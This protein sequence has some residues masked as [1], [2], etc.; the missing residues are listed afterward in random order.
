MPS[1]QNHSLRHNKVAPYRSQGYRPATRYPSAQNHSLRHN[2]VAPCRSQGYRPAT[3]YPSASNHSLR[4]NKVAPYRSQGYRPATRSRAAGL[5]VT[6]CSGAPRY[7]RARWRTAPPGASLP[8][9]WAGAQGPP[10]P[11]CVGPPRASVLKTDYYQIRTTLTCCRKNTNVFF[12]RQAVF[13]LSFSPSPRRAPSPRASPNAT[14]AAR[15]G[16]VAAVSVPGSSARR[17]RVL[18]LTLPRSRR[19]ASLLSVARSSSVGFAGVSS[20]APPNPCKTH[21]ARSAFRG[22]AEKGALQPLR[23]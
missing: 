1:A 22:F 2:K 23:I 14:S 4:H 16:F 6:L 19:R 5:K 9:R 10:V 20:L 12:Q 7:A 8:L 18:R 21:R 3:R 11:R 15:R 17:V 13:P